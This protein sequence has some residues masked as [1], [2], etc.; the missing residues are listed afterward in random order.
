MA[1]QVQW[2]ALCGLSQANRCDGCRKKCTSTQPTTAASCN[3]R[4]HISRQ[5][6]DHA[7]GAGNRSCSC[8]CHWGRLWTACWDLLNN[9]PYMCTQSRSRG[10]AA[11]PGSRIRLCMSHSGKRYPACWGPLSARRHSCMMNTA[12]GTHHE[13]GFRVRIWD[14]AQGPCRCSKRQQP[15]T[16]PQQAS[17]SSRTSGSQQKPS[18]HV[19]LGHA[20]AC[21]LVSAEKPAPQV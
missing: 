13:D 11:G 1:L 18:V 8:K 7:P 4:Q 10:P 19:P 21:L 3:C 17:A 16:V 14:G 20:V 2:S 6:E 9:Q 5:D 12:C 15:R